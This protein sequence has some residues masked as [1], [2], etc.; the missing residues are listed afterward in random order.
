MFLLPGNQVKFCIIQNT[1]GGDTDNPLGRELSEL[2][3]EKKI[4]IRETEM[5]YFMWV[6]I[7]FCLL[8]NEEGLHHRVVARN[9]FI[10]MEEKDI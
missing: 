3:Y 8:V 1:F 9:S 7:S 2:F 10:E 6:L 4:S 5:F